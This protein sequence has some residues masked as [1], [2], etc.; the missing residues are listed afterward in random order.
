MT[1]LV[2]RA[3]VLKFDTGFSDIVMAYVSFGGLLLSITGSYGHLTN[4]VLG[5][6]VYVLLRK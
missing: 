4:V 5:D 2:G 3:G 6:P 1:L